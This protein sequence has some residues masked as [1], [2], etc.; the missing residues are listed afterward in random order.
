MVSLQVLQ[1]E[2]IMNC[3]EENT[4]LIILN[5]CISFIKGGSLVC[6][7]AN[8]DFIKNMPIRFIFMAER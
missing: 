6:E 3:R 1:V 2:P 8:N 5:G 7:K 4:G